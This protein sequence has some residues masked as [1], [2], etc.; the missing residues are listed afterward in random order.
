MKI[1]LIN[2][3]YL[4]IYQKLKIQ[5]SASIPLGLL[6]VAGALER[7]GHEI[8]VFDPNLHNTPLPELISELKEFSP[9]LIGLTSVTPTFGAACTII[10]EVKKEFPQTP[11]MIGGPH[12]SV[13]PEQSLRLTPEI[14]FIIV[15]EGEETAVELTRALMED[16]S[17]F[18]PIKGL[19]YRQNGEIH[20]TPA[21]PFIEDLDSLPYPAYHLLPVKEY[22]PSVV[23][24]VREDSIFIMSSRGCPASC[25]FCANQVTGRRWRVH[26]VDYF[27]GLLNHIVNTYG[28][29][30]F[31]FVDDNFMADQARVAE[32]CKRIIAEKLKISWFIFARTDHCQDIELLKLMKEAGCVYIQFGIESGN[33]AVL[34]QLGK[35]V[36]KEVMARACQNC[37]IVGIDYFNSFMI[38]GPGETRETVRDSVD[39]AIQLDSI[40]AGFNILIPYPGTP[41]F[42]RYYQKD[43][44]NNTDW[45]RWNHITHDIPI[46]YRHTSLKKGEL[47]SLRKA[48]IRKYYLRPRQIF[49]ILTFFRSWKLIATFLKSSWEHLFFLFSRSPTNQKT[50]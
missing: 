46:D 21:R 32:I 23:Y 1:A 15:G 3:P 49:R 40:M 43:F 27:L 25:T 2:P 41:I 47:D 48:A 31:H 18:A 4:V 8:K 19:C 9:Q 28:I 12:V 20:Q 45:E 7:A 30:H 24:R 37:K 16:K 13:L 42:K 36:S 17:E 44:E 29:R 50:V 34:R 26:S 35:K 39:F 5:Q 33:E 14:D 6:Y 38:G 22:A 10:R 11:V